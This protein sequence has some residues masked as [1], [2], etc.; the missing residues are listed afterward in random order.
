M[1]YVSGIHALNIPCSLE[2]CGDWHSSALRWEDIDIRDSS[3][4]IFGDYGIEPSHRIPHH[5]G[6]YNV[7]NTIRALLDLIDDGNFAQ[8]Q[9][10]NS[11]FICN[12]AYDSEVFEKVYLLSSRDNWHEIS[13]FMGREYRTKW[14]RFLKGKENGAVSFSLSDQ[15]ASD[16]DVKRGISKNVHEDFMRCFLSFLNRHSAGYILKGGAALMLFYG[17]DRFSGD[18]DL[19]GTGRGEICAIAEEFCRENGCSFATEKDTPLTL[20]LLF[21]RDGGSTL[22]VTVSF[23]RRSLPCEDVT[24]IDG[25]LVYGISTLCRMKAN[26]YLQKERMRDLF[27]LSFIVNKYFDELDYELLLNVAEAIS[28]KGDLKQ[29]D[30]LV[31]TQHDEFIDD[32]A[33][34]ES[35]MNAIDKLGLLTDRDAG[36]NEHEKSFSNHPFA[37]K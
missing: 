10:M 28:Y 37:D 13:A 3:K 16:E 32:D 36:E 8:A 11:D 6:T 9:G 17:L 15:A 35:F 5:E 1:I 23:R 33:L 27:D 25:I 21:S 31:A 34:A 30:Y 29:F 19:D 12:P 22:R 4:S 2:T 26:A 7:A 18:I 14:L 24:R 20:V